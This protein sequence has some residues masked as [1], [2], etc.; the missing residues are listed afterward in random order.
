LVYYKKYIFSSY[1]Y[2]TDLGAVDQ[3]LTNAGFG[4][5]IKFTVTCDNTLFVAGLKQRFGFVPAKGL[6]RNLSAWQTRWALRP[7]SRSPQ[8]DDSN[9]L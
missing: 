3:R 9:L 5:T 4:K 7:K 6:F 2:G 8:N 1:K